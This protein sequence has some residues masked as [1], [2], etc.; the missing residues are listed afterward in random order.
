VRG[1]GRARRGAAILALLAVLS[2]CSGGDDDP[3]TQSPSASTTPV[4][5]PS[6]TPSAE[7]EALAAYRG[8]WQDMVA[9]ART[10]D[11]QSPLL[12][13]HATGPALT[14]I[15]QSLYRDKKD[16]VVTKGEPVLDPEVTETALDANPPRVTVEDCGDS[17][18][19]LKYRASTGELKDN[20]PGGRRHIAAT[21]VRTEGQWKV[22]GIAVSEVGT[23]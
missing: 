15:V 7:A 13:R 8:M 3:P 2:A 19:W 18:R 21:V 5:S 23:C 22:L 4:S 20:V 14:Q 1:V 10:S 17:T 6:P 11:Y 12:A 16:G 9:A